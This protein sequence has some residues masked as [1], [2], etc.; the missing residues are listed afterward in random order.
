[1]NGDNR[2]AVADLVRATMRRDRLPGVS[3]A[4]VDG[5]APV[6]AEGFGARDLAGNRP[7]TPDT[8][9]GVGSVTKSMTALAVTQIGEAGMLSVDDPVTEYLDIDLGDAYDEPIRLRH[10]LTH[11]SGLPSLGTSEALIGR[12]LRR[13]TDTVA[14]SSAA[15][16]RAHV[17]GAA[18][19][20]VA[21]PGERFAYCN[22]G[23]VL[24][25]EVVE[26][27]TGKPF[28][29]YL[30]E[31]VFDP[32]GMDRATLD[33]SRFAMD[34]D[35]MT[36]YLHEDGD[37]VAASFPAREL[38]HPTGGVIASVRHLADYLRL[39]L[40]GGR[41][42]GTEIVSADA[43]RDCHEGRIETPSGPY[44]Y[45]WRTRET[46]GRD[47]VG[48]SGSVAVSS[49]YVGFCPAEGVGVAVAANSSP[50][51]PLAHLGQGVFAAAVGEDPSDVPFF[52]RRR[53][54]D[55]LTG[56]YASYRGIRRAVVARDGG[57]LRL[58]TGG[59]LGGDGRPLE[60]TDDPYGFVAVDE[61]GAR[62]PV[63]FRVDD[64]DV[65]LLYDRWRFERV[66]DR[67]PEFE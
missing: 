19:Q 25:G 48:H 37:L 63:E 45:G 66:A 53:R 18:D 57:T 60:P 61:A 52:E 43:L 49:A 51:Y 67:A 22:A 23:Y 55:R 31:H 5:D 11:S 54:F 16:V 7:A 12:R 39:Q 27:C 47:L 28:A 4:V 15:D 41:F 42:E 14:L 3:V 35:H 9:Y 59:S 26:A 6:Y 56:E 46:C 40:N 30:D 33:D 58:E 50:D 62:E 65:T 34:D 21:P 2:A 8:L 38:T 10:L 1:M 44:G 13:E 24:L 64:G 32:L 29:A 20:R 36:P 17:E